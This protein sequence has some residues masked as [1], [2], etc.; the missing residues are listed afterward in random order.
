MLSS[1][2]HQ[3]GDCHRLQ[4]ATGNAAEHKFAQSGMAVST[5]DDEVG[6]AVGRIG[7]YR[8]ADVDIRS[9]QPLDFDVEIVTGKML[10]KIGSGQFVRPT[11]FARHHDDFDKLS[12]LKKRQ[13]IRD[14]ASGVA[15]AI[16]TYQDAIELEA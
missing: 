10:A 13:R 4:D 8:A 5:H 15:A 9:D 1:V 7:Q 14:S 3:Y 6:R 16:P 11:A 12:T 2:C